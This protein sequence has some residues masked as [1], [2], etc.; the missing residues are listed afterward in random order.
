[1]EGKEEGE[2]KV[3]CLADAGASGWRCLID[4]KPVV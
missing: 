2:K 1:M 3:H 4:D